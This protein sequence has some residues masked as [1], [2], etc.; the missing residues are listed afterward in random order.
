MTSKED[1]KKELESLARKFMVPIPR[2]EFNRHLQVYGYVDLR[3]RMISLKYPSREDLFHEFYHYLAFLRGRL[4]RNEGDAF[5]FGV[6]ELRRR[7]L[8]PSP[9]YLAR[10]K[11]WIGPKEVQIKKEEIERLLR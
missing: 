7:G 9:I 1:I 10:A 11:K 3:R 6:A 8:R 5:R 2:L 4:W